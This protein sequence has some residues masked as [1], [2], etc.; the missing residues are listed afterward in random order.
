VSLKASSTPP[1]DDIPTNDPP[2]TD[3]DAR[4]VTVILE[5]RGTGLVSELVAMLAN[6]PG[7]SGVNAGDVNVAT[8]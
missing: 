1:L 7:V 4:T 6:I 3:K 8:E 2:N 5:L